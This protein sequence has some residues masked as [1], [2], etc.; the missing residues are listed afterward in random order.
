GWAVTAVDFSVVGIELGR[1]LEAQVRVQPIT[2]VVAD[3]RTWAP[4]P[5]PD[6]GQPGHAAYDLVLCAFVHLDPPD[7][8]RARTW[9]APGG[10][11]VVVSHGP[12]APDG[13]S[14]P[15]YRYDEP[16]LRAAAEGLDVGLLDQRD[17][18]LVV[19]ARRR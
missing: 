12:G 15:A 6:P 18:R 10:H 9:L 14:N 2:W 7:F 17:D 13:P 3:L 19:I 16:Q 5:E 11:L 1:T 8:A 4:G